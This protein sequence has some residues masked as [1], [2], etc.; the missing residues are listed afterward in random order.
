M[1]QGFWE[2]PASLLWR[3][4]MLTCTGRH[5]CESAYLPG[6]LNIRLALAKGFGRFELPKPP[7]LLHGVQ[8]A[9]TFWAAGPQQ[10]LSPLPVPFTLPN[11]SSI[12]EDCGFE[13]GNSA[14]TDMRSVVERSIGTGEP[15]IIVT[16]NYRVSDS[17]GAHRGPM[18]PV[19]TIVDVNDKGGT[20]QRGTSWISVKSYRRPDGGPTRGPTEGVDLASARALC[21]SLHPV[22]NFGGER[23]TERMWTEKRET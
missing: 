3:A 15:V 9:T 8:N 16:P 19:K 23:K 13:I 7:K 11:Y 6:G 1:T 5:I 21:P 22:S 18:G 12:S 2:Y 14:D 4:T 17:V 20:S 10:V